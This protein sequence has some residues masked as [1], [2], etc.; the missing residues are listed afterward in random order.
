M[1]VGGKPMKNTTKAN[2]KNSIKKLLTFYNKKL[3]IGLLLV[4]F[5]A[6][7]FFITIE[8]Y[9]AKKLDIKIGDLAKD[10][11]RSTKE[12]VDEYATDILKSDVANNVTPK[13]RISPSIQMQMKDKISTFLDTVRDIKLQNN[14]SISKKGDILLESTDLNLSKG[15]LITALNMDFRT[16]N[17]FENLIIDLVNQ[18]M[19][20]G[21]REEELAY[22]NENLKETFNSLSITEEQKALGL[23]LILETIKP[24]ETIDI[25]E[26][27]KIRQE[28]ISKVKPVL[29]KQ[30]E[31]IAQKGDK[32]DEH[33]LSLIKESG[34]LKENNKTPFKTY[35]GMGFLLCLS[36]F[37]LVYYI[38]LFNKS[39]LY[40]NKIIILLLVMTLTIIIS[41][42]FSIISTYLIPISAGSLLIAI[43][44]E[45]KLALISHLFL[46]A[47]L[48]YNLKLDTNIIFM[49]IISG[50]IG[51][52]TSTRQNQRYSVLLKGLYI[53]AINILVISS[54]GFIQDLEFKELMIRNFF[55]LIN[56]I[57]S[58]I[59][60]LGSLPLWENVFSVLTPLKLLE[61]SNPNQPLLRQLLIE[62]PGTYHHSLMV[63]NLSE[64][65]AEVIGADPL[66][67]RVGSL[68][69][70]IGKTKKPYYFKENQFGM[71]NP[72][73]KLNP[74]HSTHIIKN[75]TLD[76]IQMAKHKKLPKEIID[77][78]EEHHGDTLVAYFY[79]KAKEEDRDV[80]LEDFRYSGRRPQTKEAALVMLADSTEAAVRS[81]K[82]P[83][84]ES[85]DEMVTKVV[86][87]K[88]N[89][90]QLD[91]CNIT[92]KDI[93]NIIDIFTSILI[94]IYHDR[95]EYPNMEN[96]TEVKV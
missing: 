28:E 78:I 64:A 71:E 62:A 83:T 36:I 92:N 9:E 24:N 81:L 30:N 50:G 69:H 90:G 95:I 55:G 74:I 2:E 52:L 41:Q 75:H 94:G 32:I 77:I 3:F 63:G 73:D 47:F 21:I 44:I 43:L 65:A 4:I 31:L 58:G 80:K 61:L 48:G 38:Y 13:Y 79:Y 1:R 85:I 84:K 14:I 35:F 91:E 76:G 70:D 45:P 12:F 33:K 5:T 49:F 82:N 60:T 27:E 8:R 51:V 7:L 23:T 53:S 72:H 57:L 19:G 17:D 89:D 68:Y 11:I 20:R 88:L 18:M 15:Q 22:E 54:Y 34:L 42:G 29:V 39:I 86:K 40:T 6:I 16:L 66:L 87:G 46:V 67:T 26:T 25:I 10:D 37:F 93:T 59:I 56:G 96:G